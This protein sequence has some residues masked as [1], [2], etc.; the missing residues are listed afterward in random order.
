HAASHHCHAIAVGDAAPGYF[1]IYREVAHRPRPGNGNAV[2]AARP[3]RM[4]LVATIKP[5]AEPA[6][7]IRTD[8]CAN[9]NDG[10]SVLQLAAWCRP[11]GRRVLRVRSHV[12]SFLSRRA[13]LPDSSDTSL[14]G[15]GKA[16]KCNFGD[17]TKNL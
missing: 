13:A 4:R 16:V 14:P 2:L 17:L 7:S 10:C 8:E 5:C 6:P 1:D 12:L 15:G 9:G 3:G 11:D